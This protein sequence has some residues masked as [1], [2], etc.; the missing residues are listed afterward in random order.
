MKTLLAAM[1]VLIAGVLAIGHVSDGFRVVTTEDA[2]RLSV[3]EYPRSLPATLVQYESGPAVPLAQSL[4]D[5]GRVTIAVFFYTRCNSVCSVV[6]SELQQMQQA[7][8]ARGLA[9]KIRLLNISFDGRDGQPELA[10][11]AQHMHALSAAWRFAQVPDA[12][13]REALLQRFGITV[14]PAPLREYQHNAA[15]HLLTPDGRLVRI[16]DYDQPETAL[17]YA[18]SLAQRGA[19]V[20]A[21][22]TPRAAS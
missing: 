5:D 7:L 20:A 15:F 13:Q 6:G 11:Y 4:R 18:V 12:R 17:D 10:A 19:P 9:H 8:Q 21:R 22:S 16:V 14:V 3:E 2:R 1:L